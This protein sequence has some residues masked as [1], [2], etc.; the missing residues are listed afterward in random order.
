MKSFFK[1]LLRW[2]L[3]IAVV[4][5]VLIIV[6]ITVSASAKKKMTP[7]ET[8]RLTEDVYAVKDRFVNMYLVKDGNGFIAIDA[9]IKPGSIRGELRKLD[10][11][12]DRVK[13]VFL[14]HSDSDHA[15]GLSL[16]KRATVF[17]HEDEEQMINGETGRILWIGNRIEP[18][19]YVLLKDRTVR[20]GDLRI[21]PVPTPGHTAGLTCYIVND[22]YLFT[23]DAV[24]LNNGVIGLF[25]RYIN[26]N[27][28][29]ARKSV[30]NITGLDGVQ[31]IFTGHHGYTDN[32]PAAV[33]GYT[34]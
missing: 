22:I 11:D 2:L 9:G 16:F 29:K 18:V 6:F 14:T 3:G 1:K 21:K 5:I 19:E 31:Y 27:A 32:Y 30:G 17:M 23:G 33:S 28:R 26:K 4:L 12:P 15:G 10:I 34:K 13:A 20:V 25:P 8:G 7:A 24:S